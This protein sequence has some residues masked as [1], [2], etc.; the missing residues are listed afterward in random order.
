MQK[1]RKVIRILSLVLLLICAIV[2]VIGVIID[3]ES[4]RDWSITIMYFEALIMMGYSLI[5]YC[6]K[7][8]CT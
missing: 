1:I 5:L 4:L 3:N 7:K 6:I 2:F 8:K